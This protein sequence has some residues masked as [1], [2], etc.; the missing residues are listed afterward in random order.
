MQVTVTE[1]RVYETLLAPAP[2]EAKSAQLSKTEKRFL[3]FFFKSVAVFTVLAVILSALQI[4]QAYEP[5]TLAWALICN[6]SV[7]AAVGMLF[8]LMHDVIINGRLE[9]E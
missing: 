3:G 6:G 2:A 7:G 5:A 1:I 9:D 4:G 8:A